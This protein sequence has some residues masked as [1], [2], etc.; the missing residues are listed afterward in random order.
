MAEEFEA[1]GYKFKT[2]DGKDNEVALCEV[3]F[4]ASGKIIL[5]KMVERNGKNYTISKIACQSISY[6]HQPSDKR[7]KPELSYKDAGI[8]Y[9][10][11]VT[12]VVVPSTIRE[13]GEK[14]F[15]ECYRL[16][17]IKLPNELQAIGARAFEKCKK[18]ASIEIPSS[19]KIIGGSAFEDCESLSKIE[20]PSS[21]KKINNC[22]FYNCKSLTKIEIPSSVEIIGE[23]AFRF[24]DKLTQVDIYNDEGE[25]TIAANAF[26]SCAKI[27]YLGKKKAPKAVAEKVVN[28]EKKEAAPA[29]GATIDL[30]KLIQATL[31]DGMVT[32]KERAVLI[33]KVKEAGGDVDEFE[34]LLDARIFEAQKKAAPAAKPAEKKAEPASKPAPAA[35]AESKARSETKSTTKP[36][37]KV[38]GDYKDSASSG[39]FFVGIKEDKK[40]VVTKAGEVCD[41]TK[42]ALREIAVKTGFKF[43]SDWT[44]QQ[45]GKK[46]VAFLNEK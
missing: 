42:A 40:V 17:T 23:R 10:S 21:V 37:A 14:A 31:A 38:E 15:F 26:P 6:Y 5:P 29:K 34:I 12:D 39:E 44:T 2:I 36:A 20:I 3:S 35:K 41:N 22:T 46:L 33:K 1:L 30:E 24:C 45:F 7:K 19:V 43:E 25:V 13:L 16:T 11:E 28:G 4:V 27:N 8:I 18:L 32:E 9:G